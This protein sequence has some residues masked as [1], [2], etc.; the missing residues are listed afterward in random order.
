RESGSD[1]AMFGYYIHSNGSIGLRSFATG[2]LPGG[3]TAFVLVFKG[4]VLG[5]FAGH[6]QAVGRCDPVGS[7]GAGNPAA[8][9]S[10]FSIA[11][12]AGHRDRGRGRPA[13]GPGPAGAGA[14]APRG[15]ARRGG[16][17]GCAA[18]PGDPGDAGVRGLRRGVLVVDGIDP[19]AG[20][21][22]RGRAAVGAGAG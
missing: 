9:L 14:A 20:E 11:G 1:V 10:T 8:E 22:R 19:G 2:L 7:V 17:R 15:R 13:P 5:V 12:G 6:L 18:V 3:G 4:V 21:V 16:A